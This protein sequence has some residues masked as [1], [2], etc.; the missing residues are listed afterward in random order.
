LSD[1]SYTER[2]VLELILEK[3]L[4]HISKDTDILGQVPRF[5]E[6]D[7]LEIEAGEDEEEDW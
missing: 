7:P 2:R 6:E 3:T 1:L 5:L 4:G